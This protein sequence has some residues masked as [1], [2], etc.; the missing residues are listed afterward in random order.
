MLA[1]TILIIVFCFIYLITNKFEEH[2]KLFLAKLI[3]LIPEP[4]N[5]RMLILIVLL[6]S[7]IAIGIA[8]FF[9]YNSTNVLP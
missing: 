3:E 6:V 7:I 9:R 8:I 4:G 1:V 2:T 5:F